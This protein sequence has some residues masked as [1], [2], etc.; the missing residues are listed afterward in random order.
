V[1]SPHRGAKLVQRG[2]AGLRG[3]ATAAA[4]VG[5]APVSPPACRGETVPATV[6]NHMRALKIRGWL[7]GVTTSW[8]A[9]FANALLKKNA[10]C[11]VSRAGKCRWSVLTSQRNATV[12]ERFSKLQKSHGANCCCSK[13]KHAGAKIPVSES[14]AKTFLGYKRAPL[15]C[16]FVQGSVPEQYLD[17]SGAVAR[18]NL[19]G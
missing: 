4:V 13:G 5:Q 17:L 8:R 2:V 11:V 1:G 6:S 16:E 18:G 15:R 3:A 19:R 12:Y 9:S 7:R 10:R 14:S